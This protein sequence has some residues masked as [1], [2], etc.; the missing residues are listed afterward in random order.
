MLGVCHHWSS[1]VCQ[2]IRGACPKPARVEQ[3]S[4]AEM[5]A[6]MTPLTV[7]TPGRPV[8]GGTPHRYDGNPPG[9]SMSVSETREP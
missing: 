9:V 5:A 8:N 7:V 6:R 2:D 1:R 4:K 3:S